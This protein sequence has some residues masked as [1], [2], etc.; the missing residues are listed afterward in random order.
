[1][2]SVESWGIAGSIVD[3]GRTGLAWLGQSRG[4]VRGFLLRALKAAPELLVHKPKSTAGMM[5]IALVPGA[6]RMLLGPNN[7]VTRS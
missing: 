2:I 4:V 3:V 5:A 1:M 6:A 7:T